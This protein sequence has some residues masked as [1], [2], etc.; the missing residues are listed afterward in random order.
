MAKDSPL[1]LGTE[2]DPI[3]IQDCSP[4]AI[5]RL[6]SQVLRSPVKILDGDEYRYAFDWGPRAYTI[7][8]ITFVIY[9]RNF[10]CSFTESESSAEDEI[11]PLS[12]NLSPEIDSGRWLTPSSDN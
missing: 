11:E 2:N 12:G 7:I 1:Q 6:S 9:F 5:S 8:F 3:V 4:T 10:V